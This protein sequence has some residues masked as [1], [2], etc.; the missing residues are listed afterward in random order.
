MLPLGKLTW[1]GRPKRVPAGVGVRLDLK[2]QAS[3]VPL[4]PSRRASGECRPE[5]ACLPEPSS[6]PG[7]SWLPLYAYHLRGLSVFVAA[8]RGCH[9]PH[10]GVQAVV[11]SFCGSWSKSTPSPC[12]TPLGSLVA[13]CWRHPPDTCFFRFW[14]YMRTSTGSFKTAVKRT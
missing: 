12:P 14:K 6:T 10:G 4:G 2:V 5:R 1:Y 3:L 7:L 11:T 8:S 13:L 9:V